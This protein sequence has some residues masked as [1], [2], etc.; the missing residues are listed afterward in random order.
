MVGYISA[1]T[2]E[3]A[4]HGAHDT[5]HSLLADVS[6]AGLVALL[7]AVVVCLALGVR[8][9]RTPLL[10]AGALGGG[11]QLAHLAEHIAQTGYWS[12]HRESAPWMTP[13]ARE[14]VSSFQSVSVGTP[15]LGMELM[16]LVGNAIFLGAAVAIYAV[17]APTSATADA[18]LA[19]FGVGTQVLHVAEH[20]A[21]TMTVVLFGRPI[22]LS[23]LF[24]TVGAG[25]ALWTYRI[26]WHMTINLLATVLVATAVTRHRH[27]ALPP[28]I[29]GACRQV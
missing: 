27:Q 25:P 24:G 12:R 9:R 1:P 17:M 19:R 3:S 15:G 10:V 2:A 21:L 28:V 7:V 14:L 22:G 29:Q 18:R 23:T 13:W 11:F 8:R 6:A 26:W 20:V 16:H 4:P 5:T